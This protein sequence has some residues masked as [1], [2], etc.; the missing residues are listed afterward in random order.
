ML[1]GSSKHPCR[2]A[3]SNEALTR[4]ASQMVKSADLSPGGRRAS[5]FLQ[6]LAELPVGGSNGVLGHC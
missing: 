5:G 6:G 2:G 1:S 3:R 4:L